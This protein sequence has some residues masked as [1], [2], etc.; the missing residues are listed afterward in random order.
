[1]RNC[2]RVSSRFALS[3]TREVMPGDV[4]HDGVFVVAGFD[5]LAGNRPARL[6]VRALVNFTG[7]LAFVMF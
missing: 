6:R 5:L 1:M 4:G 2:L 3:S 7:F